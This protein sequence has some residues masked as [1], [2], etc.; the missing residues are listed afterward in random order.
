MV[1]TNRRL[2]ALHKALSLIKDV[3][4]DTAWVMAQNI[5]AVGDAVR[6]YE[7]ARGIIS[8]GLGIVPGQQVTMENAKA[9]SEWTKQ[10]E[11]LKD[12]NAPE[13]KL[14]QVPRAKLQRD[15][16]IAGQPAI[17]ADLAPV[18]KESAPAAP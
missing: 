13:V 2:L 6:A 5:M 18:I 4:A 1:L 14:E 17:L 11:E 7:T 9:V 8:Q 3:D 16:G 15:K 12:K 10:I